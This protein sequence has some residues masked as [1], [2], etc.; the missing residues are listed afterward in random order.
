M[1]HANHGTGAPEFN[2]FDGTVAPKH[3]HVHAGRK[4]GRKMSEWHDEQM[5]MRWVVVLLNRATEMHMEL[6]GNNEALMIR[7]TKKK[8][9]AVRCT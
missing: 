5:E 6:M 8:A 1:D 4:E 7:R 3:S 2:S 9:A